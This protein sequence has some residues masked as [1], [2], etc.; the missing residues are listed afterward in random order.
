MNYYQNK[1]Q[2]KASLKTA[3]E[4]FTVYENLE[5]EFFKL[6]STKVVSLWSVGLMAGFFALTFFMDAGIAIIIFSGLCT[7]VIGFISFAT[8]WRCL[9]MKAQYYYEVLLIT[10]LLGSLERD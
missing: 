2:L 4:G 5:K 6:Y 10:Q 8:F 1:K 7:A 3:E 9:D